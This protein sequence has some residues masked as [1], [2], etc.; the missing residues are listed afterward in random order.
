M[1]YKISSVK[2]IRD[3]TMRYI[4]IYLSTVSLSSK[5]ASVFDF[6]AGFCLN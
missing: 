2:F 3:E 4:I 1:V 6:K 5:N